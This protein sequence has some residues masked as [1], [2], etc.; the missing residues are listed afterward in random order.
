MKADA[1]ADRAPGKHQLG[2]LPAGDDAAGLGR[3][4][5]VPVIAKLVQADKDTG[6]DVIHRSNEISLACLDPRRARDRPRR[7]TPDDEDF[8]VQTA[9]TRP[10]E[11]G[12]PFAHWS[13]RELAAYLRR[14]HGRVIHIGQEAKRL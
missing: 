8:V 10:N 14:S 2:A 5:R 1:A 9:T 3:R 11:L 6:R 7:L 4:N 12:Q 13:I